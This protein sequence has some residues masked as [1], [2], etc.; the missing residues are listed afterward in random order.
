MFMMTRCTV[1]CFSPTG[2]SRLLAEAVAQGTGLPLPHRI[3]DLTLPDARSA[4]ILP[5]GRELVI[6]SVPVYAGRVPAV[7]SA[8]L[9]AMSGSDSPAIILVAY[10]NRH[11]DDALLELKDL[12]SSAGFVPVAAGAFVA[13]HSLHTEIRPMAPGRPDVEDLD[14]AR[15]FGMQA[16]TTLQQGGAGGLAVPGSAPYRPYPPGKAPVPVSSDGCA[17]CG[18][19]VDFCPM[20]AISIGETL[21]TDQT[22]CIFCQAC[23]KK[24]PHQSRAADSEAANSVRERLRP[25]M[26]ARREPELFFASP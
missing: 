19:C 4:S 1:V 20:G 7:A 9:A 5:F 22:A 6:F 18:V 23:V 10:G 12:V 16:M 2:S 21:V 17:L 26:A 25:L 14:K 8:A 15:R 24:C 13:E 3:L 11:Y